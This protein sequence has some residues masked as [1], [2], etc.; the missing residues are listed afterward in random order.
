M[1]DGKVLMERLLN[2]G[3]EICIGN[4]QSTLINLEDAF[5]LFE[6]GNSMTM[7]SQATTF[8]WEK[9]VKRKKKKEK[10]ALEQQGKLNRRLSVAG[11]SMQKGDCVCACVCVCVRVH[12]L[13]HQR[14][15]ARSV[16]MRITQYELTDIG[17]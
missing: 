16:P 7:E 4:F 11:E 5:C 14:A 10:K 1:K 15:R 3:E 2:Y 12:S 9:N 8:K 17:M 6:T 13:N